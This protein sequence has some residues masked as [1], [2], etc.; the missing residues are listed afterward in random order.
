MA[1]PGIR[2]LKGRVA[3]VTGGASGIG[4]GIAVQ[5]VRAGA[6]VVIADI[7]AKALADAASAIGATPIQ[8]DVSKADSVAELARSVQSRF[9]TVHIVCNNA[10]VGSLASIADMSLS[11]WQWLINVNLWGVIHGTH[12]F[13]PILK[14]NPDGG[15]FV[16]TSSMGGLAT[17][18]GLGG[19]AVT[20]F[21]VVALSETLAQELAME[22]SKVGVTVLCPGTVRTNIA[23]STRNRPAELAQGG[24]ADVDLEKSEFGA[25]LRWLSPE[26]VGDVVV[27]AIRNGDLYAFTHPDM[28]APILERHERISSAFIRAESASAAA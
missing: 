25:N 5:L 4:R 10:G 8:V 24:L 27:A 28:K 23:K 18:P 22:E 7:E 11:D 1:M 9:G 26:S 15:H 21:G 19:Y 16:N 13:L 20:K 17:M 3:V 12:A 2:E 14:S 6:K